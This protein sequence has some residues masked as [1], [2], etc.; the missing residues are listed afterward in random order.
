MICL[1][2]AYVVIWDYYSIKR[3]WGQEEKKVFR[4]IRTVNAL[5]F[6]MRAD[7]GLSYV[8]IILIYVTIRVF[9]SFF[10]CYNYIR[11]DRLPVR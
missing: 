7:A 10:I 11:A 2:T 6:F 4:T 9:Y 1:T 3:A 8:T 5:S